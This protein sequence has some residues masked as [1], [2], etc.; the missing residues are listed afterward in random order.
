M[1]A[2]EEMKLWIE[3]S[4]EIKSE[5][6]RKNFLKEIREKLSNKTPDEHRENL[7]ALKDAAIDLR[8]EVETKLEES[9]IKV[10]PSSCEER[11]LLKTLL[12][13]MNIRFELG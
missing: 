4:A 9:E 12:S 2:R 11:E 7:I 5:K 6:E 10:Y 3:Q 13:K 1:T 8:K